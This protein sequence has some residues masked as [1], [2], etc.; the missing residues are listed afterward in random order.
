MLKC[1]QCKSNFHYRCTDLPPY[2]IVRFKI[3]GYRKYNCESCV[4]IPKD[5]PDK[6]RKR[7]QH[8]DIENNENINILKIETN[9]KNKVLASIKMAYDT[10][11]LLIEDKDELISTQEA[12]ILSLSRGDKDITQNNSSE[13]IVQKDLKLELFAKEIEDL[14]N[15]K[16]SNTDFN[17][18]EKKFEDLKEKI[19]VEVQCKNDLIKELENQISLTKGMELAFGTQ[20]DLIKSKEE[21]I[22]NMKLI[23]SL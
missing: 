17:N 21:I 9:E 8:D 19:R 10:Q 14:K 2:Q 5:L 15:S 18:N 22:E 13:I 12:I 1:S 6:C 4:D 23:K 16:N 20:K 3:Q 11:K 7:N